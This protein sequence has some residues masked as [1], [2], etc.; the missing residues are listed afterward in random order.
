M[1]ALLSESQTQIYIP[2]CEVM[3]EFVLNS[4]GSAVL[5]RMIL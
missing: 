4:P 5:L 3:A 1:R 2:L